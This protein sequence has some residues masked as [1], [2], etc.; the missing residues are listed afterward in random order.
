M[1]D[2]LISGLKNAI[3]RGA[4]M[5]QAVNSFISAGY[6]PQEVRAAA[7]ELTGG[8]SESVMSIVGENEVKSEVVKNPEEQPMST[9][10]QPLP[11]NIQKDNSEEKKRTWIIILIIAMII[12][13]LGAIGFLVYLLMK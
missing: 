12:L 9:Q 13:F 7:R 10:P 6:N 11:T 4:S 5:E 8:D 2:D 1:N 3:E